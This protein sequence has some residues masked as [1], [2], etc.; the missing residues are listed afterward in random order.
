MNQTTGLCRRGAG[1][2]RFESIRRG[3][4]EICSLTQD[5]KLPKGLLEIGCQRE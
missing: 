4:Y 1:I 2:F 5:E 3:R